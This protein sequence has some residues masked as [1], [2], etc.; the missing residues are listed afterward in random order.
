[1]DERRKQ[2]ALPTRYL[3]VHGSHRQTDSS[4]S[5]LNGWA[6]GARAGVG[7]PF[8]RN[9]ADACPRRGWA[10]AERDMRPHTRTLDLRR[11]WLWART[12][13]ETPRR[14][15]PEQNR[16]YVIYS[17][18]PVR[19]RRIHVSLAAGRAH[20]GAGGRAPLPSGQLSPAAGGES[21]RRHVQPRQT[22]HGHSL[23]N[24]DV[25]C[26]ARL[27]LWSVE[28]RLTSHHHRSGSDLGERPWLTD[29]QTARATHTHT[30][31]VRGAVKH[32]RDSRMVNRS[33]VSCHRL[34]LGGTF[35]FGATDL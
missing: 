34:F 12:Q 10:S 26:S 28:S 27:V 9:A 1:M 13:T 20:R 31:E 24:I 7:Q 15:E 14:H 5:H 35:A 23:H 19:P 32:V 21:W 6:R 18:E 29:T 8:S 16:C 4:V 11:P 2:N 30:H 33:S 25:P 3:Q 22:D 17:C